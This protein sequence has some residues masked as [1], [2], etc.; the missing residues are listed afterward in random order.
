MTPEELGRLA[1]T[2]AK[3]RERRLDAKRLMEEEEKREHLLKVQLMAE[4]R[5][6]KMSAVGGQK[7]II[8]Y[9][10]SMEPSLGD[11]DKLYAHVRAT[12]EFDLLYRRVNAAAVKARK[13]VGVEVPGIEWFPV[14]KLTISKKT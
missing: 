1:D 3:V 4:L 7:V 12:G 6:N 9:K 5:N 2:Y 10:V 11:A 8:G 14:E 13:D